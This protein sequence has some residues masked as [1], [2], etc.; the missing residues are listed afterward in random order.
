MEDALNDLSA[1]SRYRVQMGKVSPNG[2]E[3][4]VPSALRAEAPLCASLRVVDG[5]NSRKRFGADAKDVD[6]CALA[7]VEPEEVTHPPDCHDFV[8]HAPAMSRIRRSIYKIDLRKSEMVVTIHPNSEQR[9]GYSVTKARRLGNLR[10]R[11]A[12]RYVGSPRCPPSVM[13]D[14]AVLARRWALL[15]SA[16]RRTPASP[17]R[18]KACR[19][20][21]L[22]RF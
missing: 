20:V 11:A 3:K 2:Y 5:C 17:S 12:L 9:H 18:S 8:G 1:I 15:L 13:P 10:W 6:Q 4:V 22:A 14:L 19:R 21:R 16:P 7:E